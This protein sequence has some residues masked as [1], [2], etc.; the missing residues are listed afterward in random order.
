MFKMFLAL[1]VLSCGSFASIGKRACS[2]VSP[3]TTQH[4]LCVLQ[5]WC[6]VVPSGSSLHDALES[7]NILELR[8]CP[9]Y[10]VNKAREEACL[11]LCQG[12]KCQRAECAKLCVGASLTGVAY[13]LYAQDT[14]WRLKEAFRMEE[15]TERRVKDVD[16]CLV[17]SDQKVHKVLDEVAQIK[18]QFP[19]E[20]TQLTQ[21]MRA[22]GHALV[23][24][25]DMPMMF[26]HA[27]ERFGEVRARKPDTKITE[28]ELTRFAFFNAVAEALHDLDVDT[29]QS[30]KEVEAV[31][32]SLITTDV[33]H[34]V[35]RSG[36]VGFSG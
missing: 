27:K 13:E 9:Q 36:H 30:V 16:A 34:F 8:G 7:V 11:R 23:Q 31:A 18:K 29:A 1:M 19:E 28:D 20:Y 35:V 24:L 15:L 17:E 22:I 12:V 4:Q 14:R 5:H 33:E 25:Q 10:W 2:Y 6:R 32:E 3:G 21:A 26:A